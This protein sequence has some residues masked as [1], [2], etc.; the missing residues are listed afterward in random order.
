MD[1]I[2]ATSQGKPYEFMTPMI[3]DKISLDDGTAST[4]ISLP[5]WWR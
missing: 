4:A 3:G 1:R 5:I 2:L